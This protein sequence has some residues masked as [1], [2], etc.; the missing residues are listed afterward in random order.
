M[1]SLSQ[2]PIRARGV[3]L[4]NNKGPPK[5]N[6]L[7]FGGTEA[8]AE[9]TSAVHRLPCVRVVILWLEPTNMR[10]VFRF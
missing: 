1:A 3:I 9:D 4:V 2:E 8:T 7:F 6:V 10:T 5:N